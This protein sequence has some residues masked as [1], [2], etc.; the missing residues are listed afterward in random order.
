MQRS[1]SDSA[2]TKCLWDVDVEHFPT[3]G[4]ISMIVRPLHKVWQKAGINLL[5]SLHKFSEIA[6]IEYNLKSSPMKVT[7]DL[8]GNSQRCNHVKA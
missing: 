1:R 3:A 8:D 2:T 4:N 6:N 5:V 7:T